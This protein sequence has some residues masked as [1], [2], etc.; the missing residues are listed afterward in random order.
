MIGEEYLYFVDRALDGMSG[1]VKDLGYELANT[2]PA[3]AGANS[4]YAI[5]T[6]SLG[7]V[8][9]WVGAR[10]IG[11][12]DRRDRP[13]EFRATGSLGPLLERVSRARAQLAEDLVRVGEMFPSLASLTRDSSRRLVR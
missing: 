13:A 9:H 10:V 8:E 5:L 11:R 6:H 1:I 4:P 2:K 7:V 12:P 3:L